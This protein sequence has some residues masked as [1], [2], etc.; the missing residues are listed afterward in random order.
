MDTFVFF[1]TAATGPPSPSKHGIAGFEVGKLSCAM[2]VS[3]LER[4]AGCAGSF[5][6]GNAVLAAPMSLFGNKFCTAVYPW[7]SW[8]ARLQVAMQC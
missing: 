8:S 1:Q 7:P 2:K 6:S 3:G 5:P 4:P